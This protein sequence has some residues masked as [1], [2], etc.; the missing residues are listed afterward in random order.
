MS[1]SLFFFISA[2]YILWVVISGAKAKQKRDINA[3]KLSQPG[4]KDID[5]ITLTEKASFPYDDIQSA[6]Q[7]D[8]HHSYDHD[9]RDTSAG[10]DTRKH[11]ADLKDLPLAYERKQKHVV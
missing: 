7:T 10:S 3:A 8:Q 4:L 11:N 9:Y 6:Q 5:K 1:D 2:V